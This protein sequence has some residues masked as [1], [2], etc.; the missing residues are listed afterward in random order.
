MKNAGIIILILILLGLFV[1]QGQASPVAAAAPPAVPPSPVPN[2]IPMADPGTIG[3]TQPVLTTVTEPFRYT[4]ATK[5]LMP[6]FDVNGN[7]TLWFIFAA[8]GA[9]GGWVSWYSAMGY[10]NNNPGSYCTQKPPQ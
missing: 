5:A 9:P 8:S 4:S 3:V 2:P 10:L 6:Q 7:A 1:V